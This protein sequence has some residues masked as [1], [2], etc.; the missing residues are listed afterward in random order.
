MKIAVSD[1]YVLA[2]YR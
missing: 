2:S 1:E